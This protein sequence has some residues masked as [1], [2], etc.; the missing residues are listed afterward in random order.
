ML[1]ELFSSLT[2]NLK[3]VATLEDGREVI[4]NDYKVVEENRGK[5]FQHN[6]ARHVINQ[7]I[8]NKDDFIEFVKEYKEEGTKIFFNNSRIKA[9]FNYST[10]GKA[11]YHDSACEMQLEYTKNFEEFRSSLDRDLSQKDFIRILKRLESCIVGFNNKE[12]ADMDIIEV[13]ENLQSTKNFQSVQR[14]ASKAFIVD[15]EVK[16]GNTNYEIPRFIHFKMPIYKND[17]ELVVQFD[18]ELFLEAADNGFIANLVCYK[19]DETVEEAIR[20]LTKDVCES[21]EG[22]SSFM[23]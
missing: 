8:L 6:I 12:V 3:P 15:A 1:K 22:V 13:A 10:A 2:G 21:C 18:C 20:A 23:I 19:L 4:H 17:L 11:D 16:A 14:N 5:N 9:I 7:S